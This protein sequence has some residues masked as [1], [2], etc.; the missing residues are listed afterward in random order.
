MSDADTQTRQTPCASM[1]FTS[2]DQAQP[3]ASWDL[4]IGDGPAWVRAI[5]I[6]GSCPVRL[7]CYQQLVQDYPGA[8]RQL[9]S[10]SPN[11]VIWAGLA[12]SDAGQT[13]GLSSLRTLHVQRRNAAERAATQA[14]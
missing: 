8:R 13:L 12:F 9:K 14:A 10:Q 1:L 5:E 11:G 7:M 2:A 3:H 4:D 6:C